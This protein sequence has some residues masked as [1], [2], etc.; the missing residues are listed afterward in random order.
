MG[1]QTP[2]LE[3]SRSPRKGTDGFIS[4]NVSLQIDR[5]I[6]MSGVKEGLELSSA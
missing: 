1:L 3:D 6:N 5:P 2:S 4:P